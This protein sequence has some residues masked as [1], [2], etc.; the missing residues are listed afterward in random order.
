M[1]VTNTG[2][3]SLRRVFH[4]VPSRLVGHR[5]RVRLYDNRLVVYAGTDELMTLPRGRA[6]PGGRR[7]RVV[8]YR[9]VLPSLRRKPMALLNWVHRD[10]LF[11]RDAYRR[12]LT[13]CARV[14][15]TAGPAAGRWT[16]SLWPTTDAAKRSWPRRSSGASVPG[17]FPTR[18]F[19]ATGSCRRR[20][21]CRPSA[22]R[23]QRC[24]S[25]MT[26]A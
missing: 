6:G 7:G 11:P 25:T 12:A 4:T 15:T 5:L 3:F 18:R 20:R 21:A 10:G 13:R 14:R 22:R 1:R 8:N 9:H 26:P 17:S 16:C 23:C 24:R 2:G 19:C